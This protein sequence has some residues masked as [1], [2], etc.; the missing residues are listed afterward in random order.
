MIIAEA[1][2]NHNGDI[3]L[4]EKLVDAAADAGADAVKFQTFR[5]DALATFE[6]PKAAY[7]K[8]TTDVRESQLEM[9]RR[10]ELSDEGHRRVIDRCRQ[11]GITFLSS[12]FDEQSAD[13]LEGLGVPAFKIP[14]GEITNTPF[15]AHVAR[16]GLPMII[17]TGM[18][19][20]KE[21][22]RA[23]EM[24]RTAGNEKFVLLHCVS[25]YPA[26]P[27]S[28]NLRA[29]KTMETAFNCPVGY[30]DHTEGSE[31]SLAAIALGACVIEKHF[32]TDR[33]LPGPDHKASIEPHELTAF[34]AAIRNVERALGTGEKV[35]AVSEMDTARVA[36]KSIVAALDIPFGAVITIDMLAVKRPGT[37]MS[38]GM[39]D[40][41]I[42]KKARVG[43]KSGT[44]LTVDMFI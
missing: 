9:L 4:A 23:V 44:L 27:G 6:A 40:A 22:E 1:G 25:N 26:E 31:I 10:L 32:T 42:G 38:P 28:I 35:P 15:L 43:I 12:P 34:V 29:M 30:S 3:K 19:T 24:V 41:V 16:K 21:V 37:G 2:V 20:L 33:T 11:R 7:Q 8:T 18:S 39:I 36:R 17:S 14:S 5:A 13:M